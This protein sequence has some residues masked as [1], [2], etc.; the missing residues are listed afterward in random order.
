MSV[1]LSKD[2]QLRGDRAPACTGA[3]RAMLRRLR[4]GPRRPATQPSDRAATLTD[5]YDVLEGARAILDRGWLQNRWYAV[6]PTAQDS[7]AWAPAVVRAERGELTRA[8]LVGA[9][10]YASRRSQPA[11]GDPAGADARAGQALDVLWDALQEQRGWRGPGVAGRAVPREVRL[12][13][14]RDL[15]SWN[16]RSGRSSK[17]VLALLDRAL[18]RTIMEAVAPPKARS[19]A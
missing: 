11:D 7:T 14:V 19:G 10:V 1:E 8:C 15:P 4:G 12:S 13:R 6:R 2:L 16:D 18:S 17:D 9:V 3:L 5:V